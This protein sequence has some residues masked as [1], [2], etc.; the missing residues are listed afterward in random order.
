MAQSI[1]YLRHEDQVF[2]PFPPPQIEEALKTGEITPDWE[3]SLNGVDWLSIAESGQFKT[4][5]ATW[6][7]G[8]TEESVSWQEQR[9]QARK[10]WLHEGGDI[11]G[12]AHDPQLDAATRSSIE[13]DHIRTQTLIKEE[14]NKRTSPWLA[15]IVGLMLAGVGITV[16]WGQSSEPIKAGISQTIDCSAA[17]SDGVNWTGCRKPGWAQPGVTA[18]NTRMDQAQLDGANL[19]GADLSYASLI[20]VSLRNAELATVKFTG[21][22]LSGADLSGS[23][24]SGADLSYAVLSTANLTGV[25]FLATKLEKATWTDGR[26]CAPGSVDI[27]R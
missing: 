25:R 12:V 17:L 18:R 19:K 5:Q 3:T 21:A 14:I 1:W 6:S 7:A 23:D 9:L 2:G 8:E 26:V 10:R 22:D 15:V 16:W 20:K 11:T 13:R 24:L 4:D 27:C